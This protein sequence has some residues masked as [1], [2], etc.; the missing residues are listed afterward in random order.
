MRECRS[1]WLKLVKGLLRQAQ[2]TVG[3]E[4]QKSEQ[5]CLLPPE[6]DSEDPGSGD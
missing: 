2:R 6:T 4:G 5:R 3:D 1:V